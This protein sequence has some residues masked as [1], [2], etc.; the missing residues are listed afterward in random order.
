MQH[1]YYEKTQITTNTTT[2]IVATADLVVLH[3]V[4]IPVTTTGTV[5]FQDI[6]GNVY[7]TLPVA[8]VA[9]TY[10]FTDVPLKQGL[11]VVTSA[12]DN[13][14]LTWKQG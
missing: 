13:V 8:T 9:G 4:I 10:S 1:S 6:S 2:S 5:S 7:F 14:I 3:T 12:A 11:K